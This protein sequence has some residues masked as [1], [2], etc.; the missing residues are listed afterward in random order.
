MSP[1]AAPIDIGTYATVT[2]QTASQGS[3]QD[4]RP[5]PV[6]ITTAIRN[7]TVNT[8]TSRRGTRPKNGR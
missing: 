6:I 5:Y 7:E 4:T 3:V 2:V 1:S 8:P